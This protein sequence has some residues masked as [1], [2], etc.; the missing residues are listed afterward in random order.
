MSASDAGSYRQLPTTA[1]ALPAVHGDILRVSCFCIGPLSSSTPALN[2]KSIGR[3]CIEFGAL[4][5]VPG[6]DAGALNG[7]VSRCSLD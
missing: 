6:D 2:T 5:G 1:I 4:E 3:G 7:R